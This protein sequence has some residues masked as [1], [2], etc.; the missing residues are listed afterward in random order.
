MVAI[1]SELGCDIIAIKLKCMRSLRPEFANGCD[2]ST[3]FES[4]EDI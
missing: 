1:D 3:V 2:N 4:M